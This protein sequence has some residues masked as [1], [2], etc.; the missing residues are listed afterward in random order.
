MGRSRDPYTAAFNDFLKPILK[1]AGFGARSAREFG[2]VRGPIYQFIFLQLSQWGS[3]DFCVNYSAIPLFIPRERLSWVIGG[4]FPRGKTSD[5]W[6]PSK[7]LDEAEDSMKDV[8]ATFRSFAIPWFDR[9][10]SVRGLVDELMRFESSPNAHIHF[11]IGCCLAWISD[12]QSVA[13]LLNAQNL[14]ESS[15]EE[16]RS[17]DWCL[18]GASDCALL[19][20]GIAEGSS[21]AVLTDWITKTVEALKIGRL[22]RLGSE[23]ES[24]N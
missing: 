22:T 2:R 14:Y 20:N 24:P 9:T 23:E 10:A 19:L 4:R 7:A 8:A 15:Y 11:E 13:T 3:R 12:Q 6:W 5:G 1:K 21:Q 18:K 16:M 17:R